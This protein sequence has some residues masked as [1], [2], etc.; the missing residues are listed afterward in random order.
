MEPVILE[1][2]LNSVEELLIYF[3][4]VVICLYNNNN[5]NINFD[6]KLKDTTNFPLEWKKG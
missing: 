3:I 1:E 5:I 4:S 2:N 6:T